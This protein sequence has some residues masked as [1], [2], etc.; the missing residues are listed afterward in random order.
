MKPKQQTPR[1]KSCKERFVLTDFNNRYCSAVKCQEVRKDSIIE[2][3]T[4]K[5][6]KNLERSKKDQKKEWTKRKEKMKIE[7]LSTDGYRS[8]YTQPLINKI[9]RLIDNGQ[10]CIAT[11]NLGKMS[12]GHYHSVGSNRSIALNLHN[13]HIQSYESNGPKGGDQIKYRHGLI[14]VYGPEYADFVDMDLCK[15][16][17]IKVTKQELIELGPLLRSIIKRLENENKVRTPQERMDLRKQLN[18]EIGIY[19]S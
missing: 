9:A 19:H 4:A 14:R 7:N 18:I 12:G 3:Q 5:A 1:C 6:L 10:R 16:G 8:K 15:V 11:N 17:P 2:K 13:I